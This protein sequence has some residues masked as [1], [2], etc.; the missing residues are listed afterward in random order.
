MNLPLHLFLYV[1]I[2]TYLHVDLDLLTFLCLG[3]VMVVTHFLE[4]STF[5]CVYLHPGNSLFDKSILHVSAP[6]ENVPIYFTKISWC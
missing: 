6:I 5:Q 1:C 4:L 2:L 3:T